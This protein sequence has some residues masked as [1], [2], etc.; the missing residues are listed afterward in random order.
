VGRL[1]LADYD[2][3]DV[4]NLQR[5]VIFSA[6]DVGRSKVEAAAARLRGI[7]P[8]VQFDVHD[9]RVDS[10]NAMSLF[11]D[12]DVIVD[13][14]DNFAT[15]YLV[16]DACV[17]LR[18][19]HVYG[20]IFRFEGQASVF[21]AQRGPCY[22]CLFP[23]PPAPGT[24][25]DCAEGGVL[26]VLPAV[27]GSIQATE[28]LKILLGIGETLLGRVLLFDALAQRTRQITLQ[29]DRRC[30]VCGDEPQIRELIDYDAFCAA[31]VATTLDNKE[32]SMRALSAVQL[33]QKL[34]QGESPIILDVREPFEWEI[35]NLQP[36]GAQLIPL[37]DL[38]KR[39]GELSPE[40]PIVVVCRTGVRSAH[41][42]RFLTQEGFT[43]VAN[44]DGGIRAWA[45]TVDPS[46]P[47]Y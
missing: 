19:P 34:E 38:A 20:S 11:A 46:M 6:H 36:Q 23:E 9:V 37:N 25:P 26:G 29:R 4:S 10:G 8:H 1:G 31:Q 41:A 5:Q 7:N 44:L 2:V 18:K 27:I 22:R 47:Q 42:V 14:T 39:L 24:I 33:H 40:Q 15:R 12:Y 3:V 13:G 28:T 32:T 21:W 45:Q 16:N 43:D 35:C 17:L 30:A